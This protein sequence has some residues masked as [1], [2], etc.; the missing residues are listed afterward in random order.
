MLD[1]KI[2]GTAVKRGLLRADDRDDFNEAFFH[3]LEQFKAFRPP[4]PVNAKPS[5]HATLALQEEWLKKQE[6]R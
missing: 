5:S 3:A 6:G 1:P 4:L 2:H